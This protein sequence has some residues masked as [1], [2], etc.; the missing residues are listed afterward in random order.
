MT[1]RTK[2]VWRV[3]IHDRF[4][5]K[6]ARLISATHTAVMRA[7]PGPE[8]RLSVTAAAV[9]GCSMILLT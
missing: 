5:K 1:E 7:V 6:L 2:A 8:P 4:E 9:M 3:E